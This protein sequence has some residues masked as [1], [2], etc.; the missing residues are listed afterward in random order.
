MRPKVS[1]S[2]QRKCLCQDEPQL[3]RILEA[4]PL[5]SQQID[6]FQ[7]RELI[8]ISI[9]GADLPNTVLAQELPHEHLRLSGNRRF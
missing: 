1:T 3:S 7:K 4:R 2:G 5:K 6:D 8:E 9:V